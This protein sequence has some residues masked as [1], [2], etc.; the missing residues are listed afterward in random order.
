MN[1]NRQLAFSLMIN[2]QRVVATV[3]GYPT[4]NRV[5]TGTATAVL[6]RTPQ[7]NHSG[8]WPRVVTQSDPK[9]FGFCLGRYRTAR[10]FCG[11][12]NFRCNSVFALLNVSQDGIYLHCEAFAALSPPALRFAIQLIYV[13]WRSYEG[14]FSVKTT[15][16]Q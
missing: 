5:G 16:F 9:P 15:G 10:Q 2:S 8:H 14:S 1:R 13:E 12:N 4:W 11:S 6:D 3:L 7:G